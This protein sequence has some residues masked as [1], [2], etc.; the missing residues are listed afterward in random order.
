[1]S[2]YD[3]YNSHRVTI[4]NLYFRLQFL[5]IEHGISAAIFTLL[6]FKDVKFIDR[7]CLRLIVNFQLK[8]RFKN[9]YVLLY[10]FHVSSNLSKNYNLFKSLATENRITKISYFS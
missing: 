7:F 5:E 10:T 9:L 2:Y 8:N 3:L 6:F 4:I 1:M